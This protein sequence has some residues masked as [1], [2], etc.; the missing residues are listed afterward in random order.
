M[1][2]RKETFLILDGNALLHRAW[3]ALPPLTTKD[4]T[5][6]HAAYGFAMVLEKMLEQYQ[7]TYMAVAWDTKEPTFRH[8]KFKAYKAQREEKAQELYDQIPIIQNILSV[9]NI[10]SLAAP[11]FEA[12]DIIATLADQASQKEIHTFIV[13]GD[14]DALQLVDPTNTV[15][16][17]QKGISETKH[18][19]EQAVF[20]RYGFTPKQLVDYKALRGDPSDNIP[21]VP[22]IGEKTA[23]LLV[24]EHHDIAGIIQ[25]LKDGL[26]PEKFAKKL[27]GQEQVMQD[28]LDLVKMV[29]DVPISFK[30]SHSKVR[31]PDLNKLLSLYRDLE[32]RSLLRK[33]AQEI[34]PPPAP[35][36]PIFKK[37]PL[38][39]VRHLN[40]FQTDLHQLANDALGIMLLEQAQDLFGATLS[41]LIISD[42]SRTIIFP[43]PNQAAL[44]LTEQ[45]LTQASSVIVHDLKKLAHLTGWPAADR[46]FDLMLA[47]Y[48][49]HSGS[50]S[51]DLASIVNEHLQLKIAEIPEHCASDKE[52]ASLAALV[53]AYPKLAKIMSDELASTN[54]TKVFKEIEMPLIPVLFELEQNGIKLD[55]KA[56]AV[57]SKELKKEL[58]RLTKAIHEQAGEELNIN[59]PSQLA[60]ILFEKLNLPTKGI[61]KTQKGF[62]TAA[63]ELEK[64]TAAHP[65]VPL[66]SEYRELAK[67]QST[68]VEALPELVGQDGRLHTTF[69]QTVTATGR[70]SSSNPN[71]QNIPIKTE[72]GNKI[73]QAFIA[74]KGQKLIAADYSQIELRLVAHLAKDKSFINAFNEGADIHIRTAAEIA[75]I[76]ED[77]VTKEMRRAAKAINFGVIYG[78]GAHALARSTGQSF[79]EAQDFI[80]RYFILH[81]SVREYLD[82]TKA[83][84]HAEGYVETLFGRRRYLPELESGLPML[85]AS[86][87]R[88]AINMPVQGTAADLM[89]MAMIEVHGWLKQSG[90]PAK[91]LLQVHDEIVIEVASDAVDKVAKGI[92]EIME[93]IAQLSVPL[94]VDVE[95]GTNWGEMEAWKK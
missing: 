38:T 5:V 55:V 88:M 31:Q 46:Y 84:A 23:V 40:Q 86:G 54:M 20:D 95:V 29:H 13:T 90:W 62:S 52:H 35:K 47:S 32:F 83:F 87:E 16:F 44:D 36:K 1:A 69:N 58:D 14:L 19:D 94:V 33:H 17:F 43:N 61:K 76:A 2:N 11:G 77:Q 37:S 68:Y 72:L 66:I 27:K 63:P 30:F 4:G 93:N 85:V 26:I 9:F 49:L 89:K 71:L 15:V 3:H 39:V 41:G 22:G 18:Y 67:L 10:P 81:K 91:M 65:I 78:M 12:D 60:T 75:G 34:P 25:A 51:H 73:R 57:F 45:K 80:D 28:S 70:L 7:P 6:V 82:G 48:L 92:K 42:G 59:S 8:E 74:D 50:R 21:G 56:L 79:R 53:S 64:L 24:Q